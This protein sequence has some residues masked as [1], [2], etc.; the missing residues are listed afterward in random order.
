MHSTGSHHSAGRSIT[1]V[2]PSVATAISGATA[3]T[4]IPAPPSSVAN[5]SVS[6]LSDALLG[7]YVDASACCRDRCGPG[8]DESAMPDAMLT[9]HPAPRPR[10]PGT[11]AFVSR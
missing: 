3:F 2:A 11:A 7:A 5:A 4:A 6:R 9:I 8:G 10:I 1:A